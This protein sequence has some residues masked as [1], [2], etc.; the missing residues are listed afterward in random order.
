[1]LLGQRDNNLQK[2][3][4]KW[5]FFLKWVLKEGKNFLFRVLQ[6]PD[7]VEQKVLVWGRTPL[8]WVVVC[9]MVIKHFGGIRWDIDGPETL[10]ITE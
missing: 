10:L 3:R 1:M 2:Q 5:R 6:S 9:V 8:K 4:K 7:H